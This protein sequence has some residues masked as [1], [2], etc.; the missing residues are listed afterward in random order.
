MAGGVGASGGRGESSSSIGRR[1][2]S[3]SGLCITQ[4]MCAVQG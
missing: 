1:L 4:L 2:G 3:L